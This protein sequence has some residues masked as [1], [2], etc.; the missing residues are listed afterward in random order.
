MPRVSRATTHTERALDLLLYLQR[1]PRTFA[2]IRSRY[3]GVSERTL[4]RMLAELRRVADVRLDSLGRYTIP[5]RM[6]TNG[7]EW[8]SRR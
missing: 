6:F 2:A 5:I 3:P 4:W 7:D 8:R 1:Y